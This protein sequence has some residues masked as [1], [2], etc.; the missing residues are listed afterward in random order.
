VCVFEDAL[1]CIKTAKEAGF[2]VIGVYDESSKMDQKELI[3]LCDRF[4]ISFDELL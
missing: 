3:K 2:E 4:I 1:H